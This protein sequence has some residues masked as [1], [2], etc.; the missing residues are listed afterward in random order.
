MGAGRVRG[1]RGA[2]A[3]DGCGAGAATC[4]HGDVAQQRSPSGSPAV[5]GPVDLGSAA[6]TSSPRPVAGRVSGARPRVP[7]RDRRGCGNASGAA[8]AASNL[9]TSRWP[10]LAAGRRPGL[11][12]G[13]RLAS[14]GVECRLM[15]GRRRRGAGRRPRATSGWC[16]RER[17][18]GEGL[19]GG[20]GVQGATPGPAQR[21]VRM[22]ACRRGR[23]RPTAGV[24]LQIPKAKSA[25]LTEAPEPHAATRPPPS[26][27]R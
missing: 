7:R 1:G 6:C 4:S 11:G 15:G 17:M 23:A 13:H 21:L 2:G 12:R 27:R 10:K 3:G 19:R 9:P 16:C 5:P 8:A 24:L 14:A 18:C 20:G 26:R 22:K 25:T